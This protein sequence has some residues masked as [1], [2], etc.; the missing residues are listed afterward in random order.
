MVQ[1]LR[2]LL[3]RRVCSRR[4]FFVLMVSHHHRR[5]RHNFSFFH[6]RSTG[7][8]DRTL[9]SPQRY[10]RPDPRSLIFLI[11]LKQSVATPLAAS[12][13]NDDESDAPSA[14]QR[15][16]S[17]L[18]SS[19]VGALL[20]REHAGGDAAYAI[21]RLICD[22]CTASTVPARVMTNCGTFCV[23]VW[24]ERD[25]GFCAN[26]GVDK[27]GGNVLWYCVFRIGV[28]HLRFAKTQMYHLFFIPFP[29]H[30]S[31][32]SHTACTGRATQQKAQLRETAV[33]C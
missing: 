7:D 29:V 11:K 3:T 16:T 5:Q 23:V 10:L 1:G 12:H 9:H 17:S 14:G 30:I 26:Y 4:D 24:V 13:R 28:G 32:L 31:F 18:H 15:E 21:R 22:L 20:C 2:L 27:H 6:Q 8:T 33:Q 25:P 19:S